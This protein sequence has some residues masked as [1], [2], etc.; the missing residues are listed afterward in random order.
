MVG[1]EVLRRSSLWRL[2]KAV[3]AAVAMWGAM[4]AARP[5]GFIGAAVVGLIVFGVTAIAAAGPNGRRAGDGARPG[6]PRSARFDQRRTRMTDL[7]RPHP[8]RPSEQLPTLMLVS[9]PADEEV[10]RAVAAAERPCPEFLRLE[11]V[12]VSLLDWSA[13]GLDGGHRSTHRSL[14][15]AVSGWRRLD[16]RPSSPTGS[17][18]G[19]RS[20]RHAADRPEGPTPHDRAPPRLPGQDP[21]VQ[22]GQRRSVDR[23]HPRPLGQPDRRAGRASC[24][25]RPRGSRSCR[26]AV[27]VD[28]WSPCET[29]AQANLVV[30]TGREHRDFAC[31]VAAC[32][33]TARRLPH[34]QQPALTQ[35]PPHRAG[36]LA[37]QRR[38]AWSAAPRAARPVR[39]APP[40]SWCRSWP[41]RRRSASPPLLEAMA[42][43][44]AVVVE[45]HR[46]SRTAWWTTA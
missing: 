3:L 22:V 31:L 33:P 7:R 10:R 2:G 8:R 43:G 30:A 4:V 23:P 17:T 6:R 32:P 15:H 35:C 45:R 25:F 38:A 12:G 5:I 40:S 9:A 1:G 28:Y 13:L 39:R 41:L 19:S 18:S 29:A 34:R 26:I 37:S 24:A 21:G 14:R 46:R 36:R 11:Q 20:L 42:M 27:D 44:K 16:G